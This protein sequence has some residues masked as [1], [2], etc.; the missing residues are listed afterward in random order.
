MRVLSQEFGNRGLYRDDFNN[1]EKFQDYLHICLKHTNRILNR[2]APIKSSLPSPRDTPAFMCLLIIHDMHEYVT[3]YD[4]DSQ[5]KEC[6]DCNKR[7]PH[8]CFRCNYCYSSHF[9]IERIEKEHWQK[10]RNTYPVVF[11]TYTIRN[12]RK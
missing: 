9:K 12:K 3:I 6:V 1:I 4:R 2:T 5:Y 7:T 8:I 10:Q 11:T